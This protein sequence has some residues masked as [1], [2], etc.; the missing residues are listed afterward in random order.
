MLSSFAFKKVNHLLCWHFH[1]K[2]VGVLFCCMEDK[3]T[4]SIKFYS[5]Q[6]LVFYYKMG[7]IIISIS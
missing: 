5:A 2:V 4:I 1:I 6:N 3:L 7:A